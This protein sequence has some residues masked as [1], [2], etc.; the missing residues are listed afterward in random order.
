MTSSEGGMKNTFKILSYS[1]SKIMTSVIYCEIE[2]RKDFTR[3]ILKQ[4]ISTL[5]A[6]EQKIATSH[7][8]TDQTRSYDDSSSDHHWRIFIRLKYLIEGTG[9]FE[10]KTELSAENFEFLS[11]DRN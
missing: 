11:D 5:D 8:E 3:Q 9:I 10:N 1:A 2:Q 7:H 4:T 6:D